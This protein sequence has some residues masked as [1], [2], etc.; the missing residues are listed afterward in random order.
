M[1]RPSPGS[2][3][4]NYSFLFSDFYGIPECLKVWVSY[5]YTLFWVHFLLFLYFVQFWSLSF[6]LI[7][8]NFSLV[9]FYYYYPLSLFSK[10]R[11]KE[12]GSRWERRREGTGRNR[13][14][15]NCNQDILCKGGKS[16]FIKIF[17]KKKGGGGKRIEKH[18]SGCHGVLAEK[19]KR[20]LWKFI[21]IGVCISLCSMTN[22]SLRFYNE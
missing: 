10:E 16:I 1:H 9:L 6:S 2:L 17:F 3:Y 21:K 7:L 20:T 13:G 5:S 4:M 11:Q 22:T 18:A 15:R 19:K 14:R 12:S 8:I